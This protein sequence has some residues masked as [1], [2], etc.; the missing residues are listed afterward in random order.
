MYV[1]MYRG[2]PLWR[3]H[4][5]GRPTGP[6]KSGSNVPTPRVP[7]IPRHARWVIL[8]HWYALSDPTLI[9]AAKG[10]LIPH[11]G[12]VVSHQARFTYFVWQQNL[13]RNGSSWARL[14]RRPK[15]VDLSVNSLNLDSIF[16]S[17]G[18]EIWSETGYIILPCGWPF[19]PHPHIRISSQILARFRRDSDIYPDTHS[20]SKNICF[21]RLRNLTRTLGKPYER[22][23]GPF[24]P[25]RTSIKLP[26]FGPLSWNSLN[27][28]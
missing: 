10:V 24:N 12:G 19:K 15:F 23:D 16:G 27:V 14:Y 18:F 20:T 5:I 21:I 3:A 25:T 4:G 6:V 28:K 1:S 2:C 8:T 22:A 13:P 7:S 11:I 17:Y 9:W 26:K